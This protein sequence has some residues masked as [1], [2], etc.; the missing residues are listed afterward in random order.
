MRLPSLTQH[1]LQRGQ[2]RRRCLVLGALAALLL[3][4]PVSSFDVAEARVF[5]DDRAK[6]GGTMYSRIDSYPVSY[7]HLTLPT[8]S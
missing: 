6:K 4:V 7:T 8:R 5:G 2:L 1:N 3:A